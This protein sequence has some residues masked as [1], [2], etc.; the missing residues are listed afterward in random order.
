MLLLLLLLRN[1]NTNSCDVMS[2]LC[3]S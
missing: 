1:P 2:W 3:G